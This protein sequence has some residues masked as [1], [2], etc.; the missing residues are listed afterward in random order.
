[1]SG[2]QNLDMSFRYHISVLDSPIPFRLGIDLYGN[3]FDDFKFKIGKAKYK[4]SNVPVFSSVVDETRLNL[5]ESINKIFNIGVD[6]A[7]KENARMGA[8]TTFKKRI[9]YNQAVN[10][11]LD[12][13][14]A[15]ELDYMEKD[16]VN[17]S[18]AT[19]TDTFRRKTSFDKA[20]KDS[21]GT[22]E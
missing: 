12:S 1:M 14:S 8:I 9:S 15:N 4:N 5:K 21:T 11:E 16:S 6:K 20:E 2:M 18:R 3:N 22:Q 19:V 17:V 10:Q 7:L 13:L